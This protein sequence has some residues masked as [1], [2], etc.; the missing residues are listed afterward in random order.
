MVVDLRVQ[1][2]IRE[3]GDRLTDLHLT[4]RERVARLIR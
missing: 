2:I 1:L 4:R 3:G